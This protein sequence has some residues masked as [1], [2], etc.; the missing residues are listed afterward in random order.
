MQ[1]IILT[2]STRLPR[3]A[4]PTPC[5]SWS[6][7]FLSSHLALTPHLS[8]RGSHLLLH[9]LAQSV[10]GTSTP[11]AQTPHRRC[12]PN[13]VR[14]QK[15]STKYLGKKVSPSCENQKAPGASQAARWVKGTRV[16]N[17]ASNTHQRWCPG[18]FHMLRSIINS[19]E[20]PSEVLPPRKGWAV[21][22]WLFPCTPLPQLQDNRS[23]GACWTRG[24]TSGVTDMDTHRS[25]LKS[26]LQSFTAWGAVWIFNY[27]V[28]LHTDYQ[29]CS[30]EI[31]MDY[32]LHKNHGGRASPQHTL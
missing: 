29:S 31:Q 23:G 25:A 15:R 4:S 16:I 3:A 30:L 20:R 18:T 10:L 8:F 6:S 17:T 28:H 11:T 22:V 12:G 27:R 21:E 9:D 32:S 1:D 19:T 7:F 26:S 24:A 5:P 2:H 14:T 13:Q